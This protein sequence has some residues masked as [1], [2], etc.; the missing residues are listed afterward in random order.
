MANIFNTFLVIPII[1]LL[2]LIYKA[3]ILVHVPFA[4]GFSII[5]L[6]AITRLV[7]FPLTASQLKSSKKMQE[8]SPHLQRLK[9]KH[10]G[11]SKTLQSETMKLYKENGVNP[12]A[13]CVPLLIQLPFIWALYSVLNK[14]VHLGGSAVTTEVNHSVYSNSLKLSKAWDTSFF[15]LPLG[16]SPSHLIGTVGFLIILIPVITGLL[17]FIQS[18]MMF[19]STPQTDV[20]KQSEDFAASF[21]KQSAYIFP[22]MIAFLSFGFPLGLSL[23]WNTFTIFGIIQQYQI[24]G[25]G[26]LK[27]LIEKYGRKK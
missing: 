7:L 13:G 6:T 16:E 5:A 25:W 22:A 20:K 27:P 3:L 24:Q 19:S 1:N 4:F 10:K 8:L 2:V 15:G 11:D 12:A 23:Y 14:V 18:K 17:Q 26:G 9:E 21:Q